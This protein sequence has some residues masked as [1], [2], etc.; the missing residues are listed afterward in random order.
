MISASVIVSLLLGAQVMA[1]SERQQFSSCL[2]AFVD[3][4]LEERMSVPD[5]ATALPGACT[6]QESAYRA[7]YIAAATRAGDR[8]AMAEED[9][10]LEVEDLR[11]NYRELFLGSQPES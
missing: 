2:R 7:A 10:D 5:F 9:A 8:R 11:T 4:K 3:S 1:S 6:D